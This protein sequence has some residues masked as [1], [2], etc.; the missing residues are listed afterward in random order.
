MV[1]EQKRTAAYVPWATFKNAIDQLAK[2]I[3][4]RIDRSV[5][6]GIAW[7][8]QTQLFIALKFMGLLKGEDEPTPLFGTFGKGNGRGAQG[9]ADED[10]P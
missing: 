7:N 9:K 1:E 6:A 3:P 5:F 10:R 8:A 2:G 4:S